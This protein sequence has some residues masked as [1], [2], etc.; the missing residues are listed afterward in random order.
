MARITACLASW[1][2]WASAPSIAICESQWARSKLEISILIKRR[3]RLWRSWA[4]MSFMQFE[5]WKWRE[6]VRNRSLGFGRRRHRRLRRIGSREGGLRFTGRSIRNT[7]CQGNRLICLM[8]R[9]KEHSRNR[10]LHRYTIE[11]L[12]KYECCLVFFKF[13]LLLQ[14]L[15]WTFW[16]WLN[17]VAYSSFC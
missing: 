11:C 15:A 17:L 4:K 5:E 12:L 8:A 7:C 2:A 13:F 10:L 3:E 9:L 1:F 14:N 16:S 6:R